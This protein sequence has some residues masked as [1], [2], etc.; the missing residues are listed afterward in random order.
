MRPNREGGGWQEEERF[1]DLKA[2][3]EAFSSCKTSATVLGGS[4]LESSSPIPRGE[5]GYLGRAYRAGSAPL[6]GPF[7]LS[8]PGS[9]AKDATETTRASR[10]LPVP[11][12]SPFLGSRPLKRFKSTAARKGAKAH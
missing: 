1:P 8:Y 7:P 11:E 3:L 2:R 10:H 5:D 9:A 12:P 4:P 6:L